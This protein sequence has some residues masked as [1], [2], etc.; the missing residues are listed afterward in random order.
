MGTIKPALTWKT[1]CGKNRGINFNV[2]S[3]INSCVKVSLNILHKMRPNPQNL[4]W[5]IMRKKLKAEPISHCIA[6]EWWESETD[7]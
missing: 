4:K 2:I 5:Y 6:K 3:N 7:G 1:A